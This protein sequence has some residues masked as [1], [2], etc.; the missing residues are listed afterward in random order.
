[1]I[2]TWSFLP[3]DGPN[4]RIGNG[5]NLATSSTIL[6]SAIGL[7]FWMKVDNKRREGKDVD[8]ELDG[9]SI[10]AVQDLDW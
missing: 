3:F 9:L 2:S 1:L 5:L 4:F 6:L 7:L 8:A 10:K